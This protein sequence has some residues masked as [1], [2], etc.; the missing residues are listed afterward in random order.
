MAAARVFFLPDHRPNT[1][2][3]RRA[4][5]PSLDLALDRA[6]DEIAQILITAKRRLRARGK[7]ARQPDKAHGRL[8]EARRAAGM[9]HFLAAA[10]GLGLF[11]TWGNGSLARA[12]H[13]AMVFQPPVGGEGVARRSGSIARRTLQHAARFLQVFRGLGP[14]SKA[15]REPFRGRI[16]FQQ[17]RFFTKT[18]QRCSASRRRP[19]K[20]NFSL[21][22]PGPTNRIRMQHLA[23]APNECSGWQSEFRR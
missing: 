7:L 17:M 23:R 14:V 19:I 2:K 3:S 13:F 6:Q 11:P 8:T 10:F 20:G 16:F 9:A 18:S 22:A 4:L 15:A 1:L 21:P 12:A 5:A